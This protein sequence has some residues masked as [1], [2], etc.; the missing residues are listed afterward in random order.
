MA[1]YIRQQDGMS[2]SIDMYTLAVRML[3]LVAMYILLRTLSRWPYFS[4][5][6]WFP[7][8][9]AHE[10]SHLLIGVL[11]SAKPVGMS[12]GSVAITAN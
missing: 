1:L 8:T 7:A 6:L 12:L 5:L 9:F 10:L 4:A 11:F 3:M 2:Q